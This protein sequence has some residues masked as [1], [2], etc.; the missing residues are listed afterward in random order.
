LVEKLEREK[1]KHLSLDTVQDLAGVRV[2]IDCSLSEQLDLAREIAAQ[3]R[4]WRPI[5]KDIRA[6]AHSG[7]RAVHVWLRLPA[8]RVEV[9]VR[10]LSQSAWANTYE[11]IADVF[12]RGIRYGEMPKDPLA[13]KTFDFMQRMSNQIA[14]MERAQ[15][16]RNDMQADI[17]EQRDPYTSLADGYEFDE[18]GDLPILPDRVEL[19]Q[20]HLKEMA[21]LLDE[22]FEE[23]DP[24][25]YDPDSYDSEG[26]DPEDYEFGE[27]DEEADGYDKI[28]LDAR[29]DEKYERDAERLLQE[30]RASLTTFKKQLDAILDAIEDDS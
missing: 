23:Y 12:G 22:Q 27:Y 14:K 7:Y 1:D 2:D 11:R 6:R 9:Q 20:D 5:I 26:Y 28:E 24:E 10:T 30:A 8:G 25:G 15:Q 21:Q 29:A 4:T 18:L 16:H 19:A 13:R 17:D 3:F